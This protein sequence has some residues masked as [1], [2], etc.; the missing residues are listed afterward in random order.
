V[1]E[2][3]QDDSVG[4]VRFGHGG[5][6]NHRMVSLSVIVPI[7]NSGKYLRRALHSLLEEQTLKEPFEVIL[8]IDPS[9][10]DSLEIAKEY[11]AKFPSLIIDA[12]ATRMG[13]GLSRIRGIEKVSAPYFYFM[14][15]DDVLA[16]E[17]LKT[18]LETA[19]KEEADCVN[20]SFYFV[21]GKKAKAHRYPFEKR[22]TLRGKAI[23]TAYFDDSYIRGFCWTKLYKTEIAKKRPLLVLAAPLDMQFEDVALNCALLSYCTKVVSLRKPLYYY[24]KTN[25]GSAMSVKRTN[26]S[27]RH[28]VVFALERYFLEK[29]GNSEGLKAF[30]NKLPRM[31][32]SLSFDKRLDKKAGADK[33]YFKELKKDWAL[34]KDMKKPLRAEDSFFESD[35]ARAFYFANKEE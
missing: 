33:P 31:A 16:P 26:R 35:A 25:A 3:L 24:D 23:L 29:T 7:Y 2:F 10:D 20:C 34:V 27:F 19:R 1:S 6:Y 22:A 8:E 5:C 13:I 18:L 32:M 15:A 9:K 12:P 30:K 21:S 28:L 11:Q 17:A 14:D 4:K